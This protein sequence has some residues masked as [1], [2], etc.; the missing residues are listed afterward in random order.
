M[1]SLKDLKLNPSWVNNFQQ[2]PVHRFSVSAA[3]KTSCDTLVNVITNDTNQF[4]DFLN[5]EYTLSAASVSSRIL[6]V[7]NEHIIKSPLFSTLTNM[8]TDTGERFI[9]VRDMNRLGRKIINNVVASAIIS[10]EL[11]QDDDQL[12]LKDLVLKSFETQNVNTQNFTDQMWRSVFWNPDY[13]RPDKLAYFLNKNLRIDSGSNKVVTKDSGSWSGSIG[14]PGIIT[15]GGG[16]GKSVERETFNSWL[17]QNQFDVEIKGDF[18]SP[19]NVDLMRLNLHELRSSQDSATKVV[20]VRQVEV[21]GWLK[22]TVGT[23]DRISEENNY[24]RNR[25]ITF[26]QELK[27][28]G[29]EIRQLNTKMQNEV[30]LLQT[31][32]RNTTASLSQLKSVTIKECKICLYRYIHQGGNLAKPFPPVCSLWNNEI[33][34]LPDKVY[35]L[36]DFPG[37]HLY[38]DQDDYVGWYLDCRK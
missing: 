4:T 37:S 38:V 36:T 6:S 31:N 32:I 1:D 15:I 8:D 23:E 10:G 20:R 33:Q 24:L 25:L 26:E 12:S 7:K 35:N 28:K 5:L 27:T 21:P 2:H 14:I 22:V 18:F 29:T 16:R 30:Q 9:R 34:L 13:A 19:K 11:I 17:K 3:T